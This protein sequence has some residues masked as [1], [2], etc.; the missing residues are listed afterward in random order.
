VQLRLLLRLLLISGRVRT[1]DLARRNLDALLGLCRFSN[2][3]VP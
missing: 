1:L 3:A 2:R